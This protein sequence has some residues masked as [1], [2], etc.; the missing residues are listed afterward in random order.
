M[1]LLLLLRFFDYNVVFAIEEAFVGD[2]DDDGGFF[3][4]DHGDEIGERGSRRQLRHDQLGRRRAQLVHSRRVDIVV[5]G[6]AGVCFFCENENTFRM[7]A[8]KFQA[9]KF[10]TEKDIGSNTIESRKQIKTDEDRQ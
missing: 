5:P 10:Q 2:G 6:A 3:L 9:D 1:L 8:C 7:Q 4:N